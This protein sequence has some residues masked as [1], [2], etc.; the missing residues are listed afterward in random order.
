[1]THKT[2]AK[3]CKISG[4]GIH[5]GLPSTLYFKPSL[6]GNIRFIHSETNDKLIVSPSVTKNDHNRAT[7]LTNNFL[8]ISTPEH[9]LSACAALQLSSLDI[10]TTSS[11]IPICDGSAKPF[12][13]LF[14][15]TGLKLIDTLD[16]PPIYIKEPITVC[17]GDAYIIATP[18]ESSYFSYYLT[19]DHQL[20]GTQSYT[21][22]L[23]PESY[24][25]AIASARTYGFEN[26]V[27]FLKAQGLAKGG[28]L[29]NALVIGKDSFLN[30]PRF[31]NE[32]VR[33]KLLDLI[34]DC[35]V[36]NK[37]ILAHIVGIKSGH[38]LNH[39]FVNELIKQTSI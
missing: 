3:E 18:A 20:L 34:G 31:N 36:L 8:T 1:M 39:L 16:N 32:C 5:S 22:S 6:R 10:V 9:L 23:T 12:L 7:K 11:E 25:T 38:K 27:A 17:D 13:D 33:H 35:W 15:K 14:T 24:K 21:L 19:Y 4:I 37:P 2:L 30:E 26:E 29:E 28:S